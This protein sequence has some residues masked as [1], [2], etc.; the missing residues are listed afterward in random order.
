[1][2]HIVWFRND[3][4][5]NDNPALRHA[6]QKGEV[7]PLYI[8][9]PQQNIGAAS[10]VALHHALI[11]LQKKW[12]GR[13]AI[14]KGDPAAILPKI[15]Q[16]YKIESL[17]MNVSLEPQIYAQDKKLKSFLPLDMHVYNGNFLFNPSDI[18]KKDQSVY[19]VFT[20][21]YKKIY[22]EL[23]WLRA[24]YQ[25]PDLSVLKHSLP[26]SVEDLGLLPK[27]SWHLKLSSLW[28]RGEDAAEALLDRFYQHYL[29]DYE[30]ARDE[31]DKQGTSLLASYLHWGEISP[32]QIINKVKNS[33]HK[34]AFIRQLIWREFAHYN[35]FH[36][37]DMEKTNIRAT[38]DNYP[39]DNE[40]ELFERWKKGQTGY[41][42]IDAAMVELYDTGHMHNRA[43]MI[44]ASFLVK[45]LN[46]HWRQGLL[47]FHDHLIDA[48]PANNAMGWQWVAGTGI[49]ASPYF[50]IFNP[51][52]QG[53]K[54][55]PSG[56]Y[57]KKY[58][59]HLASVPSRYIHNIHETPAD[60]L[61]KAQLVLDRDYPKP[62]VDLKTSR[63]QALT[64]YSHIK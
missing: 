50:R 55:D 5:L 33:P 29:Q 19:K 61:K 41:S 8:H 22:P 48:N 38:F 37:P 56:E 35:H 24:A 3:L 11:A 49:D 62:I 6:A 43:R 13:L 17:H 27:H 10:R 51:V 14:L 26:N 57:V 47:Y 53:Q 32:Y 18:L 7:L 39:W 23:D 52:T 4:R 58:L 12:Q 20:P 1:M 60:I 59:P 63:Q 46:I 28:P 15:I 2:A 16:D 30:T 45:N 42:V 36:N 21:F 34:T 25:K 31:L 44:V 54:F 40:S 9:N 64:Y